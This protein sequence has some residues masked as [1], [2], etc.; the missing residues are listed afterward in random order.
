V[1]R[2]A[3]APK[4]FAM[5]FE[6]GQEKAPSDYVVRELREALEHVYFTDAHL[7]TYLVE[8]LDKQPRVNKAGLE[9]YGK[10]LTV[11]CFFCD[12]DNPGHAPWTDEWFEAARVQDQTLPSLTTAGVYYTR[13]GRRIVQPLVSARTLPRSA[14]R[15]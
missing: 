9:L 4:K 13:G 15:A 14:V 10:R 1:T 6:A 8:G 3:V 2:V 12:V 11:E 7:V 5:G